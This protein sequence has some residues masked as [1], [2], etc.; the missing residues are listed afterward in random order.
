[1]ALKVLSVNR[2]GLYDENDREPGGTISGEEKFY[3]RAI[4]YNQ[5][6]AK[7][8]AKLSSTT[9]NSWNVRVSIPKG[10]DWRKTRGFWIGRYFEQFG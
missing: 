9:M 2:R 4:L 8:I 7:R 10:V 6:S 3:R 1:M 5:G